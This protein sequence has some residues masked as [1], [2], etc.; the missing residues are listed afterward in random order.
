ME[1]PVPSFE[2][3]ATVSE[4]GDRY[5]DTE[6]VAGSV[7]DDFIR[8]PMLPEA[9]SVGDSDEEELAKPADFRSASMCVWW[10]AKGLAPMELGSVSETISLFGFTLSTSDASKGD[11]LHLTSPTDLSEA[12]SFVGRVLD[13]QRLAFHAGRFDVAAALNTLSR[14]EIS[15]WQAGKNGNALAVDQVARICLTILNAAEIVR[16]CN[17]RFDSAPQRSVFE[18]P[19]DSQILLAL[20]SCYLKG[21]HAFILR[22]TPTQLQTALRPWFQDASALLALAMFLFTRDDNGHKLKPPPFLKEGSTSMK[23]FHEVD[24]DVHSVPGDVTT[25]V[26]EESDILKN[27]RLQFLLEEIAKAFRLRGLLGGKLYTCTVNEALERAF[28][29]AK[30]ALSCSSQVELHVLT[31]VVCQLGCTVLGTLTQVA[32]ALKGS[33][34]D[35]MKV[36][37]FDVY[38]SVDRILLYLRGL[39][40]HDAMI[41]V[42]VA[43]L[44]AANVALA[45]CVRAY[46]K[47]NLRLE[48]LLWKPA[49]GTGRFGFMHLSELLWSQFAHLRSNLPR[50]DQIER[51]AADGGSAITADLPVSVSGSNAAVAKRIYQLGV[52]PHHL[53]LGGDWNLVRELN[54]F[55]GVTSKTSDQKGLGGTAK[56]AALKKSC[57]QLVRAV[58][59]LVDAYHTMEFS[60][61]HMPL[62]RRQTYGQAPVTTSVVPGSLFVAG[63]H[64]QT[65]RLNDCT[66]TQL[67]L[68]FGHYFCNLKVSLRLLPFISHRHH[69]TQCRYW[70]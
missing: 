5:G 67:P 53:S 63:R 57:L 23:P 17:L 51:G 55:S 21:L 12:C 11:I 46:D 61:E 70:S 19:F 65:L 34:G 69:L 16:K 29:A 38:K 31:S 59:G 44:F 25:E 48:L 4:Y 47:V 32:N 10:E 26:T 6:V 18:L 7:G 1:T 8:L 68:L 43:P 64:L 36:D 49:H 3:G 35:S 27:N 62:S 52:R 24:C 58:R 2:K 45:T 39:R 14:R 54:P 41:E 60:W 66:L 20:V 13:C 42:V 50:L 56:S 30:L 28:N 33:N 40:R 15:R 9:D 22:S 37:Y